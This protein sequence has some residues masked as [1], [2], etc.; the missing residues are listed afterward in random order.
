MIFAL[1]NITVPYTDSLHICLELLVFLLSL[2]LYIPLQ[3]SN[4]SFYTIAVIDNFMIS[5]ESDRHLGLPD[6]TR[7]G[8]QGIR[9]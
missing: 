8:C 7:K 4:P 9:E 5:F 1:Y 2:L 3:S 6:M